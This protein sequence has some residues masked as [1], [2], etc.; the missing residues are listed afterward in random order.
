MK[1]RLLIV[2]VLLLL[3]LSACAGSADTSELTPEEIQ[4]AR[5]FTSHCAACHVTKDTDVLVGPSLAGIAMT[6]AERVDG[7]DAETYIRQ[8]IIAP[9]DYLVDG[10]QNV[11]VS[12]FSQQLSTEEFDSLIAY[13]MTLDNVPEE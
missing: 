11:M 5:L 9:G 7:M 2:I 4:G 13:L 3:L 8:S 10:F 1:T 6:G 12:S